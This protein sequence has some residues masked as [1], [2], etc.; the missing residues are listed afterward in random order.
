MICGGKLPCFEDFHP[1]L[2]LKPS[3]GPPA[4]YSTIFYKTEFPR[5]ARCCT[6]ALVPPLPKNIL[7]LA[8]FLRQQEE[9]F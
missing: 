7:G 9:Y 4:Q 5:L 1:P 3:L 8:D 6:F 2:C